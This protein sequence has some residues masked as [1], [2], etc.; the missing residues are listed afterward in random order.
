M[1]AA[2]TSTVSRNFCAWAVVL[3]SLFEWLELKPLPGFVEESLRRELIEAGFADTEALGD[4]TETWIGQSENFDINNIT[5]SSYKNHTRGETSVR[6][7]PQGGLLQRSETY[8]GTI[9]DS[10]IIDQCDQWEKLS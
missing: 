1:T 6:I 9:S 3:S 7:F 5:F 2:S 10:D 8:P 4:A